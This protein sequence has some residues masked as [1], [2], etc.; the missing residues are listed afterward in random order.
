MGSIP[1]LAVRSLTGWVGVSIINDLLRLKSWSR[2]V[3]CVAAPKMPD[4]SLGAPPRYS[5][6]G[7]EDVKKNNQQNEPSKLHLMPGERCPL[8]F[9]AVLANGSFFYLSRL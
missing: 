7:D 6:V 5:L 3:S 1:A 2:S 8:M 9:S 4:V